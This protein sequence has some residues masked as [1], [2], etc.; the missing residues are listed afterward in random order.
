MIQAPR[1]TQDILPQDQPVWRHIESIITSLC[2]RHG[3]QR[4][5]TPV[6]EDTKLF[7]RTVGE[8]TDIVQKEM[9]T[10]KD[11]GGSELTLRPEGTAPVCRAYLEHGMQNLPQPLKLFYFATIYRYERPQSGRY[12]EHHQFGAEAIGDA[13]PALDAEMIDMAWTIFNSL[14]LQRLT[15]QL[16]SIGC[17]KC[18]PAYLEKLKSYYQGKTGDLCE[19]C[20]V[21][22]SRNALRL[23][24]CK[25]QMCQA[26]A[27]GSARSV[28]NLCP[29][30]HEHFEQ[31]KKYLNALGIPFNINYRLVRGLDYY[32]KTVFEV[33]PEE[34][35][36]QSTIGGGG[37]YDN[38]IEELGGKPT[39]AVGFATGI[40]RIV[41]NLKRQNLLP[42]AKPA[43]DVYVAP[44]GDEARVVAVKL[45]AELRGRGL[46]A[47]A[48]SGAK[49]LKAQMRQANAF[50]ARQVV[51]IGEEELKNQSV[52][53]KDMSTG[54]Q[55]TLPMAALADELF[56]TTGSNCK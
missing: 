31:L 54:E 53:L 12:R 42:E 50:A 36:G 43:V 24:D 17:P 48:A 15:L 41:A 47:M 5:D 2:R 23:L 46:S 6:F 44:V 51:I 28:D 25:N 26:A 34:E 4:I 35:G 20:K 11:R 30:C 9:Y 27:E 10:F 56:K 39:P 3:F 45:A 33:Q 7:V 52:L 13:D 55:K 18:R 14:G 40:E 16:N 37:R 32:T 1:G 29:E 21:R 22:A 49:S 19:D 8:A 38:L